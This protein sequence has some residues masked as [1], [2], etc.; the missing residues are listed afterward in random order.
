MEAIRHTDDTHTLVV[1]YCWRASM[2]HDSS[3]GEISL[4]DFQTL[5]ERVM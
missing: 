3:D 4:D 1:G 2:S 5:R